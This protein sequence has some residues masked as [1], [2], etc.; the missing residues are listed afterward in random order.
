MALKFNPIPKFNDHERFL[1]KINVVESGCWEW[2]GYTNKFGYGTMAITGK[3]YS[4]KKYYV[5]RISYSIFK[6]EIDEGLDID[7]ICINKKCVNPEHLREVTRKINLTENISGKSAPFLR[8]A[9]TECKRGHLYIDG[10][11]YARKDR[12]RECKECS[13][14]NR[15]SLRATPRGRAAK[16]ESDKRYR[17]KKKLDMDKGLERLSLSFGEQWQ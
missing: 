12:G 17:E 14:I 10:S 1:A 4:T 2:Q 9:M 15:R 16:L 5:H 6:K 13:A 7:H 3:M 8:R 11:F